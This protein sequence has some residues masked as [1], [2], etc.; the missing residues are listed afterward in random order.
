MGKMIR[1]VKRSSKDIVRGER[2][3]VMGNTVHHKGSRW[4]MEEP[5]R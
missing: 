2:D 4:D 1:E 5:R 3:E